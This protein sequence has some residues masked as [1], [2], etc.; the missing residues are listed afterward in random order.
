MVARQ[1]RPQP[2]DAA[3]V[4]A[5]R[6]ELASSLLE[7]QKLREHVATIESEGRQFLA[8]AAHSIRNPLTVIHSYLEILHTDLGQGLSE[9]Q[10]SFLAVAYANAV[11]LRNLVDDL[12]DLAALETGTLQIDLATVAVG[13]VVATVTSR[14]RQVAERSGVQLNDEVDGDLPAVTVDAKLLDDV[15]RRLVDNAIRF[16]PEGGTVSL[17]ARS[18]PDHA[19]IE[20][21]DNGAGI[22]AGRTADVLQ[23]FVQLHRVPGENREGFGLGLPL[24]SR[25]VRIFGGT[26]DLAS[27][28]GKG[29]TVTVRIPV[30]RGQ[31]SER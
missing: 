3:E 6:N 29:T 28:E 16:T 12:V 11:K 8:A 7:V 9:E 15:V 24:C 4:E 1:S 22:P 18:E 10:S 30:S 2:P 17:R 25:A 23:P 26:L 21:R 20:I 31:T 5:L 13:E 27:I 19:V 14:M